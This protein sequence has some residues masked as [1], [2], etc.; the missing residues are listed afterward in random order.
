MEAKELRINNWIYFPFHQENVKV[1]GIY[2]NGEEVRS[3]QVETKGTILG[4]PLLKQY[5]PIPLTEEW[6]LKFGEMSI[7]DYQIYFNIEDNHLY[8]DD[9]FSLC[10]KISWNKIKYVHQLQNL[11]F[12]LTQEELTIKK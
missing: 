5:E 3:I 2:L 10:N 8:E 7:G 12:A 1:V 9:D 4:E 11:Y 6:L